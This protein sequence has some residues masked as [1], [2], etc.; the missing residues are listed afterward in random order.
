MQWY[1]YLILCSL[2]NLALLAQDITNVQARQELDEIIITYDLNRSLKEGEPIT[3][4]FTTDNGNTWQALKGATGDVGEN[5]QPGQNKS[6]RYLINPQIV[7]QTVKCKIVIGWFGTTT[8]GGYLWDV[9]YSV[10]QTRD[11]GYIITGFTNSYGAG[12]SDVWLVKTDANGNKL[13][14]KTFGGKYSDE[15]YSVQQTSDGGYIITG[16]T[17]S[18]GAG[19]E[20]V[21]LIKTDSNGNKLWDKTFGGKYNDAGSSV[22]QT[23]D[24]GYIIT[25]YTE[26]YDA[27]DYDVWLIKTDAKGNKLWDKTFGGSKED[28]GHSVQQTSDG[29]YI[30]TGFTESYGTGWTDVW[31][32]KTDAKGN[33]LWDKTF[34]GTVWD[35]GSSV[36]QTSDGG[37][38]IT[39]W[40]NPYGFGSGHV[41]LIKTD[42]KGNKLW[43]KTF[44]GS[45]EDRG[46]SVQQTGD[47]GYIITGY[48]KSYGAGK[49]DVWLIKTDANGNKLW[50]KTF[51]GSKEDCGHSVQQTSNGG[52]I[53]T[54]YT[55]SY[56]AGEGD[57][58]LI[59]TD[60]EGNI[61]E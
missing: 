55:E 46:H 1:R 44:G 20:D 11:G 53:I 32:I 21:W 27:G 22:Q 42:A 60:A 51:G 56:G 34:G 52:Y 12:G 41:W 38:I 7:G 26:S 17:K 10:Q 6:I 19:K 36:Q 59:K 45:K 18:Y 16:Y 23:G 4:L 3:C 58:W 61:V 13:W 37:Y 28:R 29:G 49:A 2:F 31:L 8:F 40:T 33:K 9:G 39:G 15:G 25:G 54:G 48:T 35:E 30:I 14:D 47:G 50:D 57:V 43:D 5:V 24:G